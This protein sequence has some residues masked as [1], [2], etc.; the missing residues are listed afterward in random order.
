[1]TILNVY[2]STQNG[3]SYIFANGKRA[4]FIAN[5]YCTDVAAEIAEF[6]KEI[7]GHPHIYVDPAETKIDSEMLDPMKAL[8]A[9]IIAEYEAEKARATAPGNDTGDSKPVGV[10]PANSND[11]AQAA[12]GSLSSAA[13]LASFGPNK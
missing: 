7:S 3:I 9:K 13:M 2:K 5:R 12:V 1:M 6:E 4:V 8:R 11:I 10:A